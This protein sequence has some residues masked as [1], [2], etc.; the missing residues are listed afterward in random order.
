MLSPEKFGSASTFQRIAT[1]SCNVLD[2]FPD[3]QVVVLPIVL[4][5]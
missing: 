4:D 5:S 3:N 2:Q 1:T